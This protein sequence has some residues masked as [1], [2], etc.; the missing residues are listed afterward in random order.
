M[1]LVDK[2]AENLGVSDRK[3]VQIGLAVTILVHAFL[4]LVLLNIGQGSVDTTT[5]G[6]GVARLCNDIRC[7]EPPFMSDRREPDPLDV[8]EAGVIE[9]SV[10]PRL[11]LAKPA[12]GQLPRFL[13][14]EQVEKIE[15]SVNINKKNEKPQQLKN[16]KIKAKKPQL[17]RRRKNLDLGEILGDAPDDEDPRAR[18]T[19]LD[20]I[21]GQADGSVN[22]T[23]SEAREGSVFA[24]KVGE[25]IRAQFTV[26]PFI[27]Q[28]RLKNLRVRIKILKIDATGQI[29]DYRIVN[30]S[31]EDS[32]NNAAIFAIKRFAVKEGGALHLPSPDS[33]TLE[34]VNR[35]GIVVDLDGSLFRK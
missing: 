32:F 31:G 9:A 35:R 8:M 6:Y 12:K 29:L 34:L 20:R 17:D 5:Q 15:E 4:L 33:K 14:Y 27:P 21:V 3:P 1:S 24:A 22:G 18:A 16:K 28:Q 10:I 26:P 11:G 30:R 23:G 13:K 2:I 19:A 25:A 7:P